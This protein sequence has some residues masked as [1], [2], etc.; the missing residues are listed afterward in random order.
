MSDET[1]PNQAP[2]FRVKQ[3]NTGEVKYSFQGREIGPG[4]FSPSP[5]GKPPTKLVD[6]AMR[7]FGTPAST[8]KRVDGIKKPKEAPDPGRIVRTLKLL[9]EL[10]EKYTVL[11]DSSPN[12]KD[13]LTSTAHDLKER[14][15]RLLKNFKNITS[16]DLTEVEVYI[17]QA[18]R[19]LEEE[20]TLLDAKEELSSAHNQ[21]LEIKTRINNHIDLILQQELI[22]LSDLEGRIP[23]PVRQG[24][25][26]TLTKEEVSAIFE[27]ADSVTAVFQKLEDLASTLEK[28]AEE[29]E[30]LKKKADEEEKRKAEE[31]AEAEALALKQATD[32]AQAEF[33]E[34]KK[35]AELRARLVSLALSAGET[36]AQAKILSKGNKLDSTLATNLATAITQ[37][38]TSL[39]EA[40]TSPE[41]STLSAVT[42]NER[43]LKDLIATVETTLKDTRESLSVDWYNGWPEDSVRKITVK[44]NR[45][46]GI[47]GRVYIE[48]RNREGKTS[49]DND[50]Q[51]WEDCKTNFKKV[52]SD[53]L[54]FLKS[55]DVIKKKAL[56]A[57]LAVTKNNIID[58]VLSGDKDL[59]RSLTAELET[60]IEHAKEDWEKHASEIGKEKSKEK[61]S[62]EKLEA[63]K[64]R[65]VDLKKKIDEALKRGNLFILRLTDEKENLEEKWMNAR[66]EDLKK[67]DN[68]QD[69][70]D[71]ETLNKLETILLAYEKFITEKEAV[72]AKMDPQRPTKSVLRT[73]KKNP[74]GTIILRGSGSKESR[75]IS[76]KEYTEKRELGENTKKL[77]EETQKLDD[78]KHLEDKLR[79]MLIRVPTDFVKVYARKDPDNIHEWANESERKVALDL[80]KEYKMTLSG[81]IASLENRLHSR[82]PDE[83]KSQDE[84][85]Y[86]LNNKKASHRILENARYEAELEEIKVRAGALRQY[87]QTFNPEASEGM[88]HILRPGQKK[89]GTS[90]FKKF[91]KLTEGLMKKLAEAKKEEDTSKVIDP[92]SPDLIPKDVRIIG[93]NADKSQTDGMVR[94]FMDEQRRVD[95]VESLN[96]TTT[97]VLSNSA[98]PLDTDMKSTLSSLTAKDLG[99][100]S[101]F[102][103]RPHALEGL[104]EEGSDRAPTTTVENSAERKEKIARAMRVI[105]AFALA[106]AAMSAG[107]TVFS[108]KK[109]PV[110]DEIEKPV[111]TAKTLAQL[112][113][114]KDYLQTQEMKA[115]LQDVDTPTRLPFVP[116]IQKYVPSFTIDKHNPSTL[117]AISSM[118]CQTLMNEQGDVYGLNPKQREEVCAFVRKIE[119]TLQATDARNASSPGFTQNPFAYADS[120]IT[121]YAF[122][123]KMLQAIEEANKREQASKK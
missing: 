41:E 76:L 21:Y 63:L 14:N 67:I 73:A 47:K 49:Q 15:E 117:V 20:Q 29:E 16:E 81:D 43:A 110:S 120:H 106:A 6:E 83:T 79:E 31:K 98:T 121:V 55:G 11:A 119:T 71:E 89:P 111:A 62:K 12:N 18:K 123:E 115:W 35:L 103:N 94:P 68:Q 10:Y 58:A 25:I 102:P 96:R 37:L 95:T 109:E 45:A 97:E 66:G 92:S 8:P 80:L 34:Q 69:S 65:A 44:E 93:I 46:Q 23:L 60:A 112:A 19:D 64:K 82:A 28:K 42:D 107:Y 13:V 116:L 26:D 24:T 3:G 2:D 30:N 87:K 101:A 90:W 108:N 85:E 4:V 33:E 91:G 54:L 59:T 56:Y 88:K 104:E 105:S 52:F 5:S 38:T 9:E 1:M 39:T 36:L 50:V 86:E 57:N 51:S 27:E 72:F 17:A 100:D 70:P 114:W 78:A 74:G 99:L 61:E 118:E 7:R 75:T 122:Y 77:K 48:L 84:L 32:K 40:Q 53:Y 22:N 113:S